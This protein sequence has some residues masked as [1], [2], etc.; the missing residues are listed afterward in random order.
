[1]G[2][3]GRFSKQVLAAVTTGHCS[4]AENGRPERRRWLIH[5]TF[6]RMPSRLCPQILLYSVC[7]SAASLTA[8]PQAAH[9]Q[10]IQQ[11]PSFPQAPSA[12]RGI[13]SRPE[14][15][16]YPGLEHSRELARDKERHRKIVEDSNRLVKLT[17]QYRESVQRH[18]AATPEDAKLLLDVERL[19]RSVKDRMRGM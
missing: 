14:P 4:E 3:R 9:A 5:K 13:G 19:A 11:T 1:M 15:D 2:K 16:A 7:L 18:G 17:E 8:A 10:A 12:D 6:S